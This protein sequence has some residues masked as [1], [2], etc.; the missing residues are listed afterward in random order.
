MDSNTMK[1]SVVPD[2]VDDESA[3]E[4]HR[5]RSWLGLPT[6]EEKR[7]RIHDFVARLKRDLKTSQDLNKELGD[8]LKDAL[9]KNVDL[10]EQVAEL[11]EKLRVA[12]EANRANTT[13]VDF[14][15]MERQVDGPEDQATMP[16]AQVELLDDGELK[17][18]AAN[19]AAALLDRVV[20][21]TDVPAET[22]ALPALVAVRPLIVDD[23]EDDE[24]EEP[25]VYNQIGS[26]WQ[27]RPAVMQP[28]TWGRPP[29]RE[30]RADMSST[31]TF[32]VAPLQ[33]RGTGPTAIPGFSAG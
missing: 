4:T 31:G 25:E 10:T 15:F 32:R 11:T 17:P 2:L 20:P 33:Q 27:A 13:G 30:L 28:V 6:R 9:E 12:N 26:G 14:R 7:H 19:A 23:E 21:K 1:L 29:V 8:M 24:D 18:V 22:R 16:V 3:E 5:R